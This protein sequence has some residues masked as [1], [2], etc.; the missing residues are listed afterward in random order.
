[1]HVNLIFYA[2]CSW[3][4]TTGKMNG[5]GRDQF[6]ARMLSDKQLR[7]TPNFGWLRVLGPLGDWLSVCIMQVFKAKWYASAAGQDTQQV[8]ALNIIFAHFSRMRHQYNTCSLNG[9]WTLHGDS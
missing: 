8:G 5:F 3:N 4:V 9:M 2:D 7:T 1:M 6:L